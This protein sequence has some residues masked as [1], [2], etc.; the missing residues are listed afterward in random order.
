ML[1]L[2][3]PYVRG[4]LE[5]LWE[6]A[7]ETGDPVIGAVEDVEAAAEWTGEPGVLAEALIRLRF[8][9]SVETDVT[10]VTDGDGHPSRPSRWELHDYFDH[11]P[12]Y[13]K[14]RGQ[15]EQERRKAKRCDG[16]ETDFRSSD[17]RAKY[18]S[19]ACRK[20]AWR[21][22]K[23]DGETDATDRDGSRRNG[24]ESDG[25]PA[26]APTPAPTPLLHTE[27]AR[28]SE[29]RI[30]DGAAQHTWDR[31]IAAYPEQGLAKILAIQRQFFDLVRTKTLPPVDEL[32]ATVE[33]WKRSPRWREGGGRYIPGAERWLADGCFK[34][35]PPD[36]GEDRR[37]QS[38]DLERRRA[39]HDPRLESELQELFKEGGISR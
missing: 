26:P 35:Q 2:P 30:E 33:A 38:A 3:R 23:S 12:D 11:A 17:P 22:R 25:T 1:N 4:L 16:C 19:S 34:S 29:A 6:S 31:F 37:P 5:T 27:G 14:D 24:T 36:I 13:A 9:D 18:C 7:H 28:A 20:K 32:I 39:G 10:D 21:D 8:L 15:R